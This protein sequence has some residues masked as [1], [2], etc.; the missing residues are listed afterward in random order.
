MCFAD[1]GQWLYA[2]PPYQKL[3]SRF[4]Q[5]KTDPKDANGNYRLRNC[6]VEL[7]SKL[8]SETVLQCSPINQSSK[9]FRVQISTTDLV[10]YDA[11]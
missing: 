3:L 2:N 7:L 8:G 4:G 1:G 11:L 6:S 9:N 5:L 10:D